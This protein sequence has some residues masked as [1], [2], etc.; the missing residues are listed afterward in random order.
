MNNNYNYQGLFSVGKLD[1][2]WALV[3]SPMILLCQYNY[4][5]MKDH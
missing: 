1:K 4:V 3:L 5:C 2:K